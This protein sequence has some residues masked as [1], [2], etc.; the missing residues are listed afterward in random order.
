[1]C[2]RPEFASAGVRPPSTA[3]DRVSKKI[4]A[5]VLRKIGAAIETEKLR[6]GEIDR[7]AFEYVSWRAK[8]QGIHRAR[9]VRRQRAS[10]S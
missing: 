2:Q 5:R 9:R 7:C 10:D 8:R 4:P 1:M 3:E 6:C